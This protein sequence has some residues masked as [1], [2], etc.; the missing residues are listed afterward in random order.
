M[1]TTRQQQDA[2]RRQIVASAVD[3]MTRQG[4]D[5]TTMKDIA[6]AAGIGDATIYKYFPT[7]DRIVLGYLDDVAHQALAET[8][9][10]AGFGSYSL[11]EKLQ[12]LTDA[13][14]E[15]LL[16]DREFV[17]QVRTLARRSPLSMLAEPLTARQSLREA[18]ASFLEAAEASG[19][20]EPCDFKGLAGGLYTDYLAGVV[21]YWLA[22]TSDEFADTTQ[23]VDLSL[24]VLVQ[25]LR[26]GLV[27][28]VLQL[29]GFVLRSQLA[30]MVQHHSSLMG[31]L[32]LAKQAM[33]DLPSASA[34]NHT[35]SAPR[36][37]APAASEPRPAPR[38]PRAASPAPAAAARTKRAAK[39]TANARPRKSA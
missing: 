20:I 14:L 17:A 39:S 26:G 6:R 8:L 24:G 33:A 38:K 25:A 4:F 9:A 3:L 10:T 27:N 34:Y 37:A 18:V 29:G 2:T 30:R 7:K 28:R 35:A 22:D 5:G 36:P 16:A 32:Q 12:R 31:V 13:V 1:K 23:L 11:Q 21:T 15:R 19:E